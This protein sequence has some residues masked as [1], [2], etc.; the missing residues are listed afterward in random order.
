MRRLFAIPGLPKT[1]AFP[2]PV[3][4]YEFDAGSLQNTCD[5]CER[6][7]VACVP[8]SFDVGNRIAVEV[9][10]FGKVPHGPV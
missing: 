6:R 3:F 9:G 8:P 10:R 5:Y 7:S 2:A 4:V 1:Y